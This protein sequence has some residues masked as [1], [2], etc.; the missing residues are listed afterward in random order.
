MPD[1]KHISAGVENSWLGFMDAT[2]NVLLGSTT[3]APSAGNISPMRRMRGWKTGA[4]TIP[5]PAAVPITGD[6]GLIG[7]FI[8]QSNEPRTF[9]AEI[10]VNDLETD[11]YLTGTTTATIAGATMGAR[12]VSDQPEVNFCLLLNSKAKKQ[13]TGKIGVAAWTILLIPLCTGIPLGRGA[14]TEREAATFRYSFSPQASSNAPWGVTLNDILSAPEARALPMN[15]DYPMMMERITLNG[16]TTTYTL[17]QTP[18]AVANTEVYVNKA[19]VTVSSVNVANKTLTLASPGTS[20]QAA[21]VFY[22]YTP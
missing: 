3:S 2:N 12:D 9:V 6:G 21:V 18:I 4:A 16:S 11:A 19:S 5:E 14:N 15:S 7:E 1:Y 20:G 10:A 22:G 13:D 17:S 8:F